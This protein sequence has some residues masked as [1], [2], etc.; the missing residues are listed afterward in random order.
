MSVETTKK[1]IDID[2]IRLTYYLISSGIK[3][4]KMI[5]IDTEGFEFFVM[6]GFEQFLREKSLCRPAIIMEI[7]PEA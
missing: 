7:A 4:I 1:K 6:K 5:K 2:V 3:G